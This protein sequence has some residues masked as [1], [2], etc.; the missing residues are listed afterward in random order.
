MN[1]FLRNSTTKTLFSGVDR[2][3]PWINFINLVFVL[4][5]D[6]TQVDNLKEFW[7][8]KK[9]RKSP[10]LTVKLFPAKAWTSFF[11]EFVSDSFESSISTLLLAC[12]FFRRRPFRIG[13]EK[14]KNAPVA[15]KHQRDYKNCCLI[16]SA[17]NVFRINIIR[18]KWLGL[19]AWLNWPA[20]EMHLHRLFHAIENVMLSPNRKCLVY[21]GNDFMDF[22]NAELT[23]YFHYIFYS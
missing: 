17:C 9:K 21:G 4:M 11:S 18:Y 19:L 16:L 5:T 2:S 8:C 12:F 14:Q 13:A 15:Y 20:R 6:T 10:T 1:E 3:G 7:D 22:R 23:K